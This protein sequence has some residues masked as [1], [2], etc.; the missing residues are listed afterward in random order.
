MG[1]KISDI[2]VDMSGTN[3]TVTATIEDVSGIQNATVIYDS[4]SY[5]MRNSDGD[6]YTV[7]FEGNSANEYTM[8]SFD[9]VGNKAIRTPLEIVPSSTTPSTTTTTTTS[10]P[11]TGDGVDYIRSNHRRRNGLHAHHHRSRSRCCTHSG[12]CNLHEKKI[13]FN[14]R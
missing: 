7:T 4:T 9:T 1:P 12:N 10:I 11:I 6:T 3:F 5:P 14:G 13:E 2:S 8:M